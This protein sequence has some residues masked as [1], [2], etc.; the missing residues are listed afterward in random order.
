[1]RN[2]LVRTVRTFLQVF[3][4]LLIVGWADV[5]DVGDALTLASS[6]AVAAIPAVLSL[7]QN[8]LEDNTTLDVPKG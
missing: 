8:L 7:I 2:A 1:M 6:A 5:G 4:G 3:V